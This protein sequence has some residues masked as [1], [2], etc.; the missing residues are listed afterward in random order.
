MTHDVTWTDTRIL[1]VPLTPEE[2]QEA[3]DQLARALQKKGDAELEEA[4]RRKEFKEAVERMDHE[5]THWQRL[6]LERSRQEPVEVAVRYDGQDD[7]ILAARKDTGEVLY[8]R[9]ATRDEREL[10][11]MKA[12]AQRQ[13]ELALERQAAADA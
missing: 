3:G 1:P 8:R 4:T 12:E 5:V 10:A 9:R 13:Q 2:L 6:V 7:E 11:R